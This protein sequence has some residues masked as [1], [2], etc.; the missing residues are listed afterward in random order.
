MEGCIIG[1]TST[2]EAACMP[3]P[4]GAAELGVA[5]DAPRAGALLN[6]A[7]RPPVH[8]ALGRYAAGY[9]QLRAGPAFQGPA[10]GRPEASGLSELDR[11]WS[12]GSR[13]ERSAR[14]HGSR[15]GRSARWGP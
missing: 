7:V 14:R 15:R 13:T 8:T 10:P 12:Y 2:P 4:E 11:T 6:W 3:P 1:L 9:H 5:A